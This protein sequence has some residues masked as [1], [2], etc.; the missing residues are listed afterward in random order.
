MEKQPP[1]AGTASFMG[2]WGGGTIFS[3]SLSIPA[4]VPFIP[5]YTSCLDYRL[6]L[7][8]TIYVNTKHPSVVAAP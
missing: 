5:C 7:S 2:K 8:F 6:I 1:F 4:S 3:D